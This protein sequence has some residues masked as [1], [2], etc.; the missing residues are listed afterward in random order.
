MA[1]DEGVA[2][3]VRGALRSGCP[4]PF[5]EKRMFGGLA[6]MVRGHMCVGVVGDAVMARVGPVRHA[7]MLAWPH[8]RP[9]DFTGRPMTGFLFVDPAAIE[10]DAELERVLAACLAFND[11]LPDR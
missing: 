1:Y 7:E 2:A 6:F 8:V 3:R 4:T 5:V 10:E 9:M 11:D